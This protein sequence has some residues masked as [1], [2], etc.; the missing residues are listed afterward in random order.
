MKKVKYLAMVFAALSFAACTDDVVDAQQDGSANGSGAGTPAYLTISFAANEGSST[1]ANSGDTHGTEEDSGHQ[2]AGVTGESTITN[3]LVVVSPQSTGPD[4][5]GFAK[6][7]TVNSTAGEGDFAVVDKTTDSYSTVNPI[8]INT[9]SYNVLVVLNPASALTSA[10]TTGGEEDETLTK[11]ITTTATVR[12]IYNKILNDAYTYSAGSGT[13]NYENAAA[14]IGMKGGSDGNT[15]Y[16]MMANKAATTVEVT[17]ANT[18]ENPAQA[19][20]TVERTLSKVTFRPTTPVDGGQNI[21]PVEVSLGSA[22]AITVTGAIAKPAQNPP[23]TPEYDFVTLNQATDAV[24]NTIYA[25]YNEKG[26]FQGAYKQGSTYSGGDAPAGSGT[27][28]IYTALEAKLVKDYNESTETDK[29]NKYYAVEDAD[30]DNTLDTDEK[31][32][33]TLTLDPNAPIQKENWYV[34]LEGYSLI[35]LAKSVNYVRHTIAQGGA[36]QAPFGTL[37]TTNYLWTPNFEAKNALDVT[38]DFTT[39]IGADWYYNPLSAVS[40][41]SKNLTVGSDGNIDWVET[42]GYFKA[43]G[44]TDGGDATGNVGSEPADLGILLAYCFENSTDA[45]HQVHG[46]S[47]GISFVARIFKDKSCTQPIEKLY[48]YADHNYTKL[49]EINEAYGGTIQA[50]KELA[51]KEAAGTAITKE[52]LA[53]AGV[54]EYNGNLCYYYTTEIK[55]FDNSKD[56]ERGVNEFIIMRNNIY[57]L[58][59]STINEIGAPF[60]DPTPNTP[61]ES[62]EAALDITVK[63]TP[64]IVRYNDI[65]F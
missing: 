57:S 29:A 63:L 50:I 35:N 6:L 65:E 42:N 58:A 60:V 14:S 54:T 5:D 61:N 16:F 32:D 2:S 11:G 38:T 55:H 3:A 18:P 17:V 25:L 24:G 51:E 47:T 62:E 43:F 30:S 10:Y 1:R 31:D 9:G 52:E 64:W 33:I 13:D 53:N 39:S 46:L 21:Y 45:T 59:V 34:R 48:L 56:A 49:A 12:E 44:S 37:S 28:Y 41:E 4:A 19:N 8:T 20:V 40:A 36:M 15:P 27:I 26:V 23:A 22:P 7:Y